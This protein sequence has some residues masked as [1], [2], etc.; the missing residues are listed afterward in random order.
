MEEENALEVRSYNR[1]YP[2]TLFYIIYIYIS[3]WLEGVQ[4]PDCASLI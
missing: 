2:H 3:L 4:T 1:A